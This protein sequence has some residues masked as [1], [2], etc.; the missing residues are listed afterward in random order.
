MTMSY[1]SEIIK[2]G[3]ALNI[4]LV[5]IILF[6]LVKTKVLKVHTDT[7]QLG[8][9]ED[10]RAIVRRQW[11]YARTALQGAIREF[12]EGL[13]KDKTENIL[14]ELNNIFEDMIVFNHI[15]DDTGYIEIKQ[16]IVYNKILSLTTH[17]FFKTD[18]FKSLSDK[19]VSDIIKMLV[20]IRKT[21]KS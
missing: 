17:D 10:E 2:S 20:R 3:N 14:H 4:I 1:I 15:K 11:E 12:P 6:I 9:H 8:A 16:H 18:E 5:G 13:N 19:T 7:L 21:Y